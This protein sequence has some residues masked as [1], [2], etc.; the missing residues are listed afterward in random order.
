MRMSREGAHR[1]QLVFTAGPLTPA[2]SRDHARAVA[3]AEQAAANH[4]SLVTALELRLRLARDLRDHKAFYLPCNI[5]FRCV[6][7]CVCV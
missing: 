2:E 6:R 4:R 5:D 1:G 7:L 3:V